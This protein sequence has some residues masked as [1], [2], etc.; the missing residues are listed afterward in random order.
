MHRHEVKSSALQS[1]G[2]DPN[3]KIL[4]LE[5]KDNGGVWQYFGVGKAIFKRF[6]T[7]DSLGRF[8]VTKVKGK[9]PE[10]KII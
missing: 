2:Y 5:F 6:M 4:E 10:L 7:S 9:Y 8:F 1:V 3:S